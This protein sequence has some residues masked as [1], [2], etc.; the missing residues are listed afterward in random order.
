[1]TLPPRSESGS[2]GNETPSGWRGVHATT[3]L[4]TILERIGLA[5]DRFPSPAPGRSC[6][7]GRHVP[8][9][10]WSTGGPTP[11][12]RKHQV[13]KGPSSLSRTNVFRSRMLTV[14]KTKTTRL[15]PTPVRVWACGELGAPPAPV[16]P[17]PLGAGPG[18]CGPSHRDGGPPWPRAGPR[19]AGRT[20]RCVIAPAPARRPGPGVSRAQGDGEDDP[21]QVRP[22]PGLDPARR[23]PPAGPRGSPGT[24]GGAIGPPIARAHPSPLEERDDMPTATTVRRIT[25]AKQRNFGRIY[26]VFPVPDLTEIQ[27]R[28]YERFLQA[29]I[30]AEQRD[31]SGLEGV[32]REIFPIESYDKTLKLEYIKYDL[33]KPRYEPDECRQLRL[34][35]GRPLHVWLRLNKGETA[36]EESVYLG[37]MP[38]MI[39][40][41]EFIINGAE[42][43]VVSQ[44]HR[45]P[46][47]DFVVEIE[48]GDTQAPRLPDHPRARQLDR[49]PGHQ[50]GDP[51][52][53][54]RPVGQ[55]LGDDPAPRHEPAVLD[56]RG[57]PRSLLRD[58]D[59]RR[60]A[61]P[62]RPPSSKGGSPAATSSTRHTGEVLIESGTTISK[63]S[64]QDPGRRRS[65]ATITVLEGGQGHADPPVAPGGPDHRPRERPAPDLPAAPAGQPAAAREGQGALPREVLRH[66]PLPPGQG[67][68]V[69]DQPQVQ[70]ERSPEDQMTLDPDDYVNAIRYI[71][72]LRKGRG[73]RR[74][75]R[76]P[77]QPPAPDDRRAGRRRAP[78]GLPQAP[79]DRPGAD[80][81]QGRR[82]HDPAVADQPQ[83]HQRGDRVLLRPRRAVAGRR[84]DQPA[85]PAHPRAPALG[86]SARA[87]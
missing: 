58:R 17:P 39:G 67:R 13:F 87:A 81:P 1:M 80:E 21:H 23:P 5:A 76:P 2:S 63:T 65:S 86:A 30:P 47:V 20:I 18:R 35:Y 4:A 79:P 3:R 11:P 27:T 33:G 82:G 19:D 61:T 60:P 9:D 64:A 66:Q 42:R 29:D 31:D 70:P 77:G 28:S 72:N 46:G 16:G 74:R 44:L 59:G 45:S 69:P 55:V 75:H 34:T 56:R 24:F 10:C 14:F 84:P 50:E 38:I 37:D 32:F 78:Q 6:P 48:A 8:R 53:P 41:G 83:E 7:T 54:D 15:D 12:D 52:R 43:V 40:G 68:P 51:R 73:A 25:P 62:R 57:D 71:L 22:L 26:D 49:A 36:I 85:G